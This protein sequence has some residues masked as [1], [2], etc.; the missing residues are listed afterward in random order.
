MTIFFWVS[1]QIDTFA[2]IYLIFCS[3][4]PPS[5]DLLSKDDLSNK[6]K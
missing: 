6:K 1:N 2:K 4:F 3:F 5:C